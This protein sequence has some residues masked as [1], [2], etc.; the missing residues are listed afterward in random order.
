[1][2]PSL[3]VRDQGGAALGALSL[4]LPRVLAAEALTLDEWF[5]LGDTAR[6][7]LRAQLGVSDGGGG[8]ALG[9]GPPDRPLSPPP[10]SWCP[11]T[12]AWKASVALRC[13]SR[14]RSCAWA[15]MGGLGLL[16]RSC[17]SVCPTATG[18][19][20]EVH[21]AW[22]SNLRQPRWGCQLCPG[23]GYHNTPNNVHVR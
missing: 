22:G 17:A 11:S 15:R 3:Q 1:M 13:L 10:R 18:R 7:L 9:L 23:G 14:S 19:W 2:C 5:P 8:H 12:Q 21:P 4:P 20:G 6:I 16:G